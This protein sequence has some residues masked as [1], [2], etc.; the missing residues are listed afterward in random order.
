MTGIKIAIRKMQRKYYTY[1]VKN[2]QLYVEI[3]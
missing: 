2:R 3:I 1:E